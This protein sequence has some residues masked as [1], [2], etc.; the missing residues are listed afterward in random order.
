MERKGSTKWKSLHTVQKEKCGEN[1]GWDLSKKCPKYGE[2]PDGARKNRLLGLKRVTC[3]R[4]IAGIWIQ[5]G[6]MG[7]KIDGRTGKNERVPSKNRPKTDLKR[8]KAGKTEI[9][10]WKRWGGEGAKK[11]ALLPI[12]Q[13][14]E[15]AKWEQMN[16]SRIFFRWS[17]AGNA[18]MLY[19][20]TRNREATLLQ[21]RVTL[22]K[23]RGSESAAVIFESLT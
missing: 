21:E 2:V 3:P 8:G 20:C 22:W 17:L 23:R 16:F 11:W 18:E 13:C 15:V 5:N 10:E 4:K 1:K 7:K 9:L 19:L 12:L 6:R 14:Y